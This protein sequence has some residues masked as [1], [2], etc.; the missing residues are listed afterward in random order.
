MVQG[1]K[2]QV[3]APGVL[4]DAYPADQNSGN[5][6]VSSMIEQ[7][8]HGSLSMTN[9]TGAF[10]YTPN[11]DYSGLDWFTWQVKDGSG[12]GPY[13]SVFIDVQPVLAT[14]SIDG[15]APEDPNS[16]VP[17]PTQGQA[18]SPDAQQQYSTLNLGFAA[19]LP[20]GSKI[21]LSVDDASSV[22]AWNGVPGASGSQKILGSGTSSKT[23]TIGSDQTIPMSLDLVGSSTSSSGNVVFTLAVAPSLEE[24][25]AGA[26]TYA[27]S[28]SGGVQVQQPATVEVVKPVIVGFFGANGPGWVYPE[29]GLN[30]G[31]VELVKIANDVGA[32]SGGDNY[33]HRLFLD[34]SR[35]SAFGALLKQLDTNGDGKYDPYHPVIRNGQ[36]LPPD[37]LRSIEIFGHSWGGYTAV[38]LAMQ[39]NNSRAF[40]ADNS[41]ALLATI[42]PVSFLRAVDGPTDV[43]SNVSTYW[44]R[45]RSKGAGV[46]ILGLINPHGVY[47]QSNATITDEKD[48]NPDG[49]HRTINYTPH[50]KHLI[51]NHFN[52]INEVENELEGILIDGPS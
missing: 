24:V 48:L 42:D 32:L 3:D 6:S 15:N 12:S 18:Q 10:T 5:P 47:I 50:G 40:A 36:E 21:T 30:A 34:E 46:N 7:P 23:W 25:G 33:K 49:L 9:S 20:A 13:A 38:Q 17:D 52:I 28:P 39:I 8:Q 29:G 14:L 31:N 35:A 19:G 4:S 2:L 22:Q 41:I 1:G 27:P 44:N 51:I 26:M 11:P 45:Y 43:P 16:V 37:Q